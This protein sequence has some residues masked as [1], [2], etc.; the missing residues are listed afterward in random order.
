MRRE[1]IA[2][3]KQYRA[4]LVPASRLTARTTPHGAAQ[5]HISL[6]SAAR[7]GFVPR[8][9]ARGSQS[10]LIWGDGGRSRL[11]AVVST[12]AGHSLGCFSGQPELHPGVKPLVLGQTSSHHSV[13]GEEKVL[14]PVTL[15]LP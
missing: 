3:L 12:A 11:A 2:G 5:R 14:K 4:Y 7:G 13:A 1:F 10:P 9:V 6:P 15:E 8:T